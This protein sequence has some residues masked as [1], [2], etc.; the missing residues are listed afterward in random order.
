MA[1][2][3]LSSVGGA[4]GGPLGAAIGATVGGMIDRAA[5]AGLQPARQVGPRLQTLQIMSA[6]E[7]APMAAVF[8]RARVAGQ[9]I[10]A[11]RFKERRVEQRSGGGKGGPR[12]VEYRYSL[13]FAVALCEGP[14][15]GVGRVWADGKPL[16]LTGLAMRVHS[17]REDQTPDPLIEAVE[18]AA[19]AFAAAPMWCSRTCRWKPS[20]TGR[21]SCRSRCFAGRRRRAAWKSG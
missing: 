15:D 6:A 4:L 17:G 2:V 20:A 13:S 1:Q 19:P 21:R 14:I 3:I 9:V 10:W 18:G 7:G 12:T 11:A 16:D 8:G 5:V